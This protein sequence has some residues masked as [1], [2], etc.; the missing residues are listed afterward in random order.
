MDRRE[1]RSSCSTER[2]PTTPYRVRQQASGNTRV[3]AVNK[4]P[5]CRLL[6]V[7]YAI[8]ACRVILNIRAAAKGGR[9]RSS[10][11]SQIVMS[12]NGT[13]RVEVRGRRYLEDTSVWF[14]ASLVVD[15]EYE[16]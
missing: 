8:L 4:N 1:D 14:G 11:Q 16:T 15:E 12:Y 13:T 3:S 9:R 5:P 10:S 6:R 7:L 2:I